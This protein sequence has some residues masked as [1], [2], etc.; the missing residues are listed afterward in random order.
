MD[1]G[2]AGEVGGRVDQELEGD[3]RAAAF[4][5]RERDP[6]GDVA[7]GAVA[8]D[9]EACGV[10]AQAG[11][12]PGDPA[13][14]GVAVLQRGGEAV[15][16]RKPVVHGGHQA[17]GVMAEIAADIVVGVEVAADPAAAVD[18]DQDRQRAS[19]RVVG[20]V[21]AHA[22]RPGRTGGLFLAYGLHRQRRTGNG[23]HLLLPQRAR[24][25]RR[26]LL[27]RRLGARVERGENLRKPGV[28]LHPVSGSRR[29]APV[30]RRRRRRAAPRRRRRRAPPRRRSARARPA[31][32]GAA[33]RA[34]PCG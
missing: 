24:V 29:G 27:D 28:E 15:L 19:A 21:D 23:R 5:R 12:V 25:L 6:A 26:H 13:G 34:S 9:G 22:E 14:R 17:A 8:A 32:G 4:A 33:R 11:G 2:L 1:S 20:F 16:R 7:A 18:V 31:G 30:R 10:G 3:R